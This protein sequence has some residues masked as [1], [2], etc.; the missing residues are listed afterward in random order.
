RRHTRSKRDWSSD[1]CSSDLEHDLVAEIDRLLFL[2]LPFAEACYTSFVTHDITS[3]R[4][5]N[6]SH[7]TSPFHVL[8]SAQ[9]QG[10]T[11][12]PAAEYRRG[13]SRESRRKTISS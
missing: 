2:T 3:S 6:L 11:N 4:S 5:G 9:V 8:P 10:T 1:V 12:G 7:F 13:R